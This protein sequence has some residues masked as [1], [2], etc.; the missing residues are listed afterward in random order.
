MNGNLIKNS[1]FGAL[2]G[3]VLAVVMVFLIG[4]VA[5]NTKDPDSLTAIAAHIARFFGAAAAGFAAA[6]INREKG[7][8]VGG[9][10]GVIY[11]LFLMLGSAFFDNNFKFFI[12][13]LLCLI[14]IVISALFGIIGLPKVKSGMARRKEIMKRKGIG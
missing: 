9:I 6:K 3:L 12:S 8:I 11:S 13:L 2:V 5:L 4:V 7:L 10:S 14:C 1:F